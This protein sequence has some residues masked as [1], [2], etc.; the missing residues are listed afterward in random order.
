MR[1][2]IQDTAHNSIDNLVNYIFNYT[3]KSPTETIEKIYEH[4]YK[5]ENYSYIGRYIPEMSDKHFRE[6]YTKNP[7]IPNIELCT[8]YLK[9]QKQFI[10]L[11]S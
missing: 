2:I 9:L 4:I 6:L 11:I 8:T 5:L 1:I 3:F 10:Y 7:D